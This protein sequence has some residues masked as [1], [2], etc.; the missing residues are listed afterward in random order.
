MKQNID[1][2]YTTVIKSFY[3]TG[4]V[5]VPR[6]SEEWNIIEMDWPVL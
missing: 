5:I 3:E 4:Q 1:F 6:G 2:C